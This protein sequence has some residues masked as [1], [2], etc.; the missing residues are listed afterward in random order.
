MICE[1][2][3]EDK[4]T[5]E[6]YTTKKGYT[7]KKCNNCRLICRRKWKNN[8]KGSY[9]QKLESMIN[10][11]FCRIY[12]EDRRCYKGVKMKFE[13]RKEM[14][15]YIHDNFESEIKALLNEGLSPSIDRIDPNK[16]YERGNIRILEKMKNVK[17][18]LKN[19]HEKR[20]IKL[21][22]IFND[23]EYM[24]NSIREASNELKIPYGSLYDVFRG[25]NSKKYNL[26]IEE[27]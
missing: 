16:N 14:K 22:V 21:K 20:K 10:N 15:E 9:E 3:K 25:G 13:S 5:N 6:Y 1:M 12:N 23:E 2:C 4:D 18:G 8:R 7:Y 26:K 24:F 17:L 19:A 27:I 11:A